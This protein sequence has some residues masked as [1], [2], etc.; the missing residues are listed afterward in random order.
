M[1]LK[2]RDNDAALQLVYQLSIDLAGDPE[3]V[4]AVQALTKDQSRPLIGLRGAH[5][6]FGSDEWWGNIQSG[7]LP[8]RQVS[9]VIKRLFV[10]G[11]EPNSEVNTF[12]LL[13]DSGSKHIESIYTNNEVSRGLFKLESRV[14]ILYALDELKMQPAANGGVN[15]SEIV[16]EMA[17]YASNT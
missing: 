11:Q 14:E 2:S 16:L 10:S 8:I 17:I 13:L 6:L 9:G 12:E 7:V 3:Q 15:Y 5:G 1:F 4:K